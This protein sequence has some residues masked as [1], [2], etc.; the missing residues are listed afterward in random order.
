MFLSYEGV[1]RY[2]LVRGLD[3]SGPL[4][5]GKSDL[6]GKTRGTALPRVLI[7]DDERLIADTLTQIFNMHGFDAFCAYSG[8]DA[9]HLAES[10]RPDYLLADVMMPKL[11]G[12]DLAMA[13][14]R[15]IPNLKVLL[16]SGQA[17]TTAS[18]HA[19]QIGDQGFTIAAKPMHPEELVQKL[20]TVQPRF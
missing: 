7:V 9:L 3:G 2:D 4:L 16:F 11:N 19:Q 18:M 14:E 20:R 10:F 1:S 5:D 17:S 13:M 6:S 12:I 15:K 8:V